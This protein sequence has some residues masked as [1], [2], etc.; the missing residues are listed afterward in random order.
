M[1]HKIMLKYM[2]FPNNNAH[3]K[4]L[5]HIWTEYLKQKGIVLLPQ[6]FQFDKAHLEIKISL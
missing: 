1:Q 6:K 4:M 5:C 2:E 3:R